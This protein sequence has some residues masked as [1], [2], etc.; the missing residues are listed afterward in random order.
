MISRRRYYSPPREYRRSRTRTP[1][2][3]RTRSRDNSYVRVSSEKH[4]HYL[5]GPR[6][7]ETRQSGNSYTPP[8]VKATPAPVP[9]AIDRRMLYASY[10]GV[11][12]VL[13]PDLVPHPASHMPM[14]GSGFN[15]FPGRNR[16]SGGSFDS[17]GW[18]ILAALGVAVF[19]L[20]NT[21][22]MNTENGGNFDNFDGGNNQFF[23]F[24]RKR[25]R[26]QFDGHSNSGETYASS[27]SEIF[28]QGILFST[29]TI[30]LR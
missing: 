16:D 26:R 19:F 25:K 28:H 29:G 23:N 18:V 22:L 15:G 7:V 27:L 30:I 8:T 1:S 13:M 4:F 10:G 6:I 9:A 21:I 11:N 17:D 12:P 24:K 3:Y 5:P 2:R 14:A 20:R